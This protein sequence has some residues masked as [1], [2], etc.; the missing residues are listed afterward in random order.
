MG[1]S[2]GLGTSNLSAELLFAVRMQ[3]TGWRVPRVQGVMRA[4]ADGKAL[5]DLG[6]VS[7]SMDG[8]GA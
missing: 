6:R 2:A 1:I 8:H 7:S 3:L 4:P 5:S